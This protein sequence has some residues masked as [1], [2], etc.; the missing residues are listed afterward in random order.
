MSVSLHVGTHDY[1]IGTGDFFH[2]FFSTI[3]VRLEAGEWGSRYPTLMRELYASA[4]EPEQVGAAIVELAAIDQGL[5]SL[6]PGD[7]V[8]D[9]ADRAALPPW[10]TDIAPTTHT[11]RDY[12]VTMDGKILV[13]VLAVA[14]DD[15]RRTAQGL[16]IY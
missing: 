10:G 14:L 1:P 12:F 3:C 8:W 6:P 13:E 9:V 16:D 11:L 7:V 5:A 2:A 4:L 15:A